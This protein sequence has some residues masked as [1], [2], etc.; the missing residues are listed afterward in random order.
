MLQ[1]CLILA[2]AANQMPQAQ[3][4]IALV[5][6]FHLQCQSMLSPWKNCS[7]KI[8]RLPKG[9]AGKQSK[10]ERTTKAFRRGG[11]NA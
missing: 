6:R 4:Q 7:G 11:R 2:L 9:A 5:S 8:K 10:F 3:P 1:A